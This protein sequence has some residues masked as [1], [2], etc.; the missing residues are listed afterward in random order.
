MRA[1]CEGTSWRIPE[2][3]IKSASKVCGSGVRW[4]WS[5]VTFGASQ[6]SSTNNKW[7]VV[8]TWFHEADKFRRIAW[9]VPP[10]AS[11]SS[12]SWRCWRSSASR[13][14]CCSRPRWRCARGLAGLVARNNLKQIRPRL[15]CVHRESRRPAAVGVGYGP[16]L[17]VGYARRSLDEG[18]VTRLPGPAIPLQRHQLLSTDQPLCRSVCPLFRQCDRHRDPPRP[19]PLPVRRG[20]R[21]LGGVRGRGRRGVGRWRQPT[22]RT[23][24]A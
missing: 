15:A 8:A 22:I 9:S 24:W 17:G 2:R 10:A 5:Q 16:P 21:R 20:R 1:L 12:N 4:H 3:F 11:R 7:T 18:P 14:P 23:T 19:V 6:A 13:S